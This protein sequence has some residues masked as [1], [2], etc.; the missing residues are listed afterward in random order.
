MNGLKQGCTTGGP[1]CHFVWP[2]KRSD[3]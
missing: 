2:A 3:N 1:Q